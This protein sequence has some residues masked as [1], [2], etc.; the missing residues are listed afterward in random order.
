VSIERESPATP[1]AKNSQPACETNAGTWERE[2]A[3]YKKQFIESQ[4]WN[5]KQAASYI[6]DALACLR[7]G[8]LTILPAQGEAPADALPVF[9]FRTPQGWRL[10]FLLQL[11]VSERLRPE[12]DAPGVGLGARERVFAMTAKQGLPPEGDLLKNAMEESE[13]KRIIAQQ[14]ARDLE[15]ICVSD[16]FQTAGDSVW[17]AILVAYRFGRRQLLSEIYAD[18]EVLEENMRGRLM[19]RKG[20]SAKGRKSPKSPLREFRQR[21]Q[22]LVHE[23]F[24]HGRDAHT[25]LPFVRKRLRDEGMVD[26]GANF[27]FRDATARKETLSKWVREEFR[28]LRV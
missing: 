13:L 21:A 19:N 14:A 11:Q 24:R 22:S 18:E 5:D 15:N 1:A 3:D 8:R 9:Q 17:Q 20:K 6:R 26:E 12:M 28:K 7:N 23:G 27:V 2:L 25:I 4:G 16:E 10:P